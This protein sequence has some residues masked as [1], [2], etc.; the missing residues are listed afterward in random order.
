MKDS[1]EKYHGRQ[2]GGS[3]SIRKP[4]G[5]EML[6][7]EEVGD[8]HFHAAAY[9]SA[10]DYYNQLMADDILPSIPGLRAVG[11]LRKGIDANILLGDFSEAERLIETGLATVGMLRSVGEEE[12]ADINE[13]VLQGR[14]SIIQR[15]RGNLRPALDLA[16]RAFAVL[17]LTDEHSEVARL[18]VAMGVCHARLGQLEKAEEFFGDGLSTFRRIGDDLGVANALNNLSLLNKNRCHWDRS[19]ALID[20]AIELAQKLGASQLFPALHLN[21]GI[22][23]Q[24]I[25]RLGES[26]A[27]LEK[28]L[29][30]AR[31]LGD[32]LHQGRL[33]LARGRLE[34]MSRRLAHAEELVLDG[35]MLADRNAFRRESAL[36]DELLGDIQMARGESDK[37]LYNYRIGLEK[38]RAIAA[39]NDLEGEL[40]RRC[41]A[42]HLA[43]ARFDEAV[44]MAQ[45]AIAVCEKCGEH[46][47]IG[48]C[49][50]TLGQAYTAQ[51]DQ[52][53]ADHHFRQS[54]ATFNQQNLNHLRFRA[55][56]AFTDARLPSAGEAELLLLRR[57]LMDAQ[58]S[59]AGAVS[60]RMLCRV[61][62]R[63]ALVQIQLG[64]LDDALLTVFELERFAAGVEDARLDGTVIELRDRIESGLLSAVHGAE[65]HLHAISGIPDIKFGRGI[66][67][68]RNLQSVLMA[69]LERVQAEMG[70]IALSDGGEDARRFGV[71]ARNGMTQNLCLQ[72][73]GW[74]GGEL[75]SGRRIGT[76]IF[77][78]LSESSELI[79]AVPALAP[80]AGSCLFMPIAM[81][82]RTLG[83]LFMAKSGKTESR[84]FDRTALDFLTTYMGFLALYLFEKGH[85]RS[86]EGSPTET[87]PQTDRAFRKIVTRD[88]RM[89]EVLALAK[90]VAPSDL[91]VLLN[92]QTGTG[93]GLV[94]RAIHSMSPRSER[95]FV[96]INCAAIPETLLE[97]ELF[98]HVRGSFTGAE[99]DKKGLLAEAEGGTVFLDEIGKMPLNMQGK[100]LQFL[101]TKVVRPVG[102]NRESIVDVRII[103]ASKSDLNDLAD[104]GGFLEDLYYR[105]L[106]FPLSIPPLR[107]RRVD[108]ELLARHF[109]ELYG[110]ELSVTTP[111]LSQACLDI[112]EGHSWPGN[113]RE[114]EKSL[115]RALVLASD[116]GVLLP[117]H[118]PSS[119]LGSI[120]SGDS[121]SGVAPLRETLAEIECREIARALELS[122]GNKSQAARTLKISYP[123]LLKKIRLYGIDVS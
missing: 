120:R 38:S 88:A 75:R 13:A 95:R 103:C 62:H 41:A 104:T 28:G 34:L 52:L 46:Y 109:I 117:E 17:A 49:H 90:K 121:D 55:I 69:G 43:E 89:L 76:G 64:Q 54:I 85:G 78:R 81:H 19:L 47:E 108:V 92:G 99:S 112:L 45:A 118:L 60:D 32:R 100:L 77:S 51:G 58:E 98:G 61:L 79:T 18:Q 16:K 119:M 10:L 68:P 50:L 22:I 59:G 30:L 37:A 86:H 93:K 94:A 21:R 83:L 29:R 53:Q 115:K 101:D 23:L 1:F 33:L 87:D 39:D 56:I 74:Y 63:L 48:F 40:L 70:F 35:K 114:L 91:T 57:Y 27:T 122:Q 31:S 111:M 42:V 97:S 11:L 106:D 8:L 7:L 84:A 102:S 72:L 12:A 123:S 36:A 2:T 71:C 3:R 116:D 6:H 66:T 107:E 14:R 73:A 9:S 24:K 110:Q 44:G 105:L 20:N 80:V 96:S 25:D 113:V 5:V 65:D 4:H 26:R 15:E 67:L 82:G